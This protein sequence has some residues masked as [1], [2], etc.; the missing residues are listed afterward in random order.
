MKVKETIEE[1]EEFATRMEW[2]I[3]ARFILYGLATTIVI[4]RIFIESC[5]FDLIIVYITLS[6]IFLNFSYLF[7][8]R[9]RLYLYA[10][11]YVSLLIDILFITLGTHSQGGLAATIFPL[12]YIV[13][14]LG[15]SI[16][17]S[18][19]AG[20][21]IA[22][23]S[24]IAVVILVSLECLNLLPFASYK[25]IGL[26]MYQDK[27]YV[28]MIVISRVIFFYAVAIVSGYLADRIKGQAREI[29]EK[30]QQLIYMERMAMAAK[31]AGESAHEI[32]NPLAVIKSGLYY[33]KRILPDN[34]LAK[35]TI[36]RMDGATQR[37]VTYINDLL[38]FSKPPM[39]N[40]KTVDLH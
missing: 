33:L 28:M 10:V 8:T 11:A 7:L 22:T 15:A 37:A 24:S 31:I 29:R 40:L 32:K 9:K 3:I 34:E 36:S 1:R 16:L 21:I 13:I 30:G 25:A 17:I 4:G 5:P 14:I 20:I 6:I 2:L 23:V 38:N 39:L 18:K 27:G 19:R 26:A 12:N 35:R